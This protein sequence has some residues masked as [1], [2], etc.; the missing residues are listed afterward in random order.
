VKAPGKVPTELQKY[1][2]KELSQAGFEVYVIDDV[3]KLEI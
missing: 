3:N 1:R 2:H